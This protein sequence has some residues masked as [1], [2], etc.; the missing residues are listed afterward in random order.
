VLVLGAGIAVLPVLFAVGILAGADAWQDL[1]TFP[2]T[3]FRVVR[4][5]QYPGL[6]PR[7]DPI[8]AWLREPT[9]LRRAQR[10]GAAVHDWVS[11][12]GPQW[13]FCV[14]AVGLLSLAWRRRAPELAA[15]MAVPLACMP[16]FWMAAHVQINTHVFSMALLSAL[17]LPLLWELCSQFSGRAYLLRLALVALYSVYAIGMLVSPLM[18][19]ARLSVEAAELRPLDLPGTSH[20]QV[21]ARDYAIYRPITE[22]IRANVREGEPIQVVV[23]RSDAVVIG[24]ADFYF[25]ADR[26]VATRYHELHPGIVDRDDIQQEM[27]RDLERKAVRCLVRWNFGWSDARLDRILAGRRRN[28]PELGAR[29]LDRYVEE[30]FRV[31][32]RHGAYDVMW[33]RGAPRPWKSDEPGF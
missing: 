33:R 13:V 3:D 27:I 17:L 25:L 2:A 20:T 16:F 5:E 6:L 26:P 24:N 29:R 15:A 12:N 19:V 9:D 11:T 7:L 14:A 30:N 31:V 23:R 32:R 8:V 4:G 18:R 10:A 21:S 22:F 28:L 1:V